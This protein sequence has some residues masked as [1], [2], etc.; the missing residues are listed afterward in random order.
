MA[1]ET[2]KRTDYFEN[3]EGRL[4]GRTRTDVKIGDD[5]HERFFNYP[6]VRFADLTPEAQ[7]HL[8]G[9]H[10][11]ADGNQIDVICFKDADAADA[12]LDFCSRNRLAAPARDTILRKFTEP[13][14]KKAKALLKDLIVEMLGEGDQDGAMEL[15]EKVREADEKGLVGLWRE[16]IKSE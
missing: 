5:V 9:P 11:D 8:L 6:R 7:Q 3:S 14:A 13:T 2:K 15:A 16:Y 4:I 10:Y 12:A 1:T